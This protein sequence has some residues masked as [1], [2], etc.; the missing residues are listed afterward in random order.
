[1]PISNIKGNEFEIRF[2]N[3]SFSRYAVLFKNNIINSLKKLGVQSYQVKV[4]EEILA[5]KK[6]HAEVSWPA[7]H[8]GPMADG[9]FR[10]IFQK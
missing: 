10:C 8:T 4:K 1:M 6:A 3:N 2:T 7:A 5:T 9:T